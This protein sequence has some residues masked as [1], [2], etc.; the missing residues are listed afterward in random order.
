MAPAIHPSAKPC[1]LPMPISAMPIVA[2]VVHDDPVITLTRAQI[3]QL[4]TRNMSGWMM[5]MP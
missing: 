3:M 4:D 5:C 1:A 2:M